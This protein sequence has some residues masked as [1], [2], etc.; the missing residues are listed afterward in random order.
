MTQQFRFCGNSFRAD[1]YMGCTFGCDYCFANNRKFSNKGNFDTIRLLDIEDI[2]RQY[3]SINEPKIT[4]NI[5]KALN[6][7]LLQ[8]NV[9]IHLGGMSDPFQP[10]EF[11]FGNTMKFLKIFKDYPIVISTKTSYL[12]DEYFDIID[13]KTKTF[14]IS[15][16]TDNDETLNKFEANTP[17][18]E[19]RINFIKLLK[20]KGYWVSVRIQPIINIDE[21]ISLIKKLD[22]IVD[23]ITVEHLKVSS[24]CPNKQRMEFFKK[25][26]IDAGKYKLRH[27]YYKLPFM[28]IKNNIAKIKEVYKGN[29]GCGDN[30][31]L[32]EST[33]CNCCG[34]DTMPIA[35][36]NWIGYNYL[37]IAKTGHKEHWYPQSRINT[38]IIMTSTF[39]KHNPNDTIKVYVDE[40]CT[41]IYKLGC[42]GLF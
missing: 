20:S 35:F 5:F 41:D 34:L 24:S 21:A 3:N 2:E 40:Y 23:Y 4:T 7:E 28:D 6:Q 10:C 17:T 19:E 33:T 39:K 15:L 27:N 11:K 22:E 8:H 38:G 9:P 29:L 36:K 14:Q 25:L 12:P 30:E 1:T 16:F 32:T 26:G 37:N 13:P 18:V 31:M 42:S